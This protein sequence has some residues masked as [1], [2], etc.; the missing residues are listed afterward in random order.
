MTVSLTELL[1]ELYSVILVEE[2]PSQNCFGFNSVILVTHSTAICDSLVYIPPY[3]AYSGEF[4]IDLLY[5]PPQDLNMILRYPQ[6]VVGGI[7][8]YPAIPRKRRCDRY[9][10]SL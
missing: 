10:Y 8:R 3:S 4:S 1:W 7:A 9:S 5:T 6:K 2:L